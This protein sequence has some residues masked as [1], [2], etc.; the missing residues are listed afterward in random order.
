MYENVWAAA[1]AISFS[2]QFAYSFEFFIKFLNFN[3]EYESFTYYI[4]HYLSFMVI[5]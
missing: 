3:V 1:T 2:F 5:K 4:L